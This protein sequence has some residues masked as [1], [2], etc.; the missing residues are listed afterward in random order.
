MRTESQVSHAQHGLQHRGSCRAGEWRSLHQ[1]GIDNMSELKGND[2]YLQ[3]R[4][5]AFLLA[6]FLWACQ[7][8]MKTQVFLSPMDHQSCV[9]IYSSVWNHSLETVC[10]E[11]RS[12]MSSLSSL[13]GVN[14]QCLLPSCALSVLLSYCFLLRISP[15]VCGVTADLFW[16]FSLT[17]H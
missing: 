7:D 6:P 11:G 3:G 9:Y 10:L 4:L 12:T 17:Q 2:P 14:S 16:G 15:R 13:C 1:T 5:E 8:M